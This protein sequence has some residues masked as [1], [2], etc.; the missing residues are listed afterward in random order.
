MLLRDDIS[1]AGLVRATQRLAEKGDRITH[2]GVCPMSEELIRAPIELASEYDFPVLFVASR[3]QVSEDEEGGYVMGLTP[4]SFARKIANV[5]NLLGLNSDSSSNYIRFISVDH[6]GPWYKERE[7]KLDEEEATKS[8]KRT[9]ITCLKASYSGF[10]IDCSFKPPLSVEMNEEKMIKLTVDLIEFTERK[11]IA[12]GKGTVSYEIGTE[13]TAGKSVSLEHFSSSIKSILSEIK[14]R[15]LPEP[16]F[17]VGRTGAEI[18]M[19]E[20][21]GGFDYTAASYLPE[22]ARHFH[23]GFKEHNADY[24]SNPIL[25]LHPHYGITAANVGPSFAAEQTR[26]LLS[27]AEIEPRKID[28]DS[29]NLYEIMSQAVLEKAPFHKWLRKEDEWTADE[30][31]AMPAELRA[32]TVVCGHYVYYDEKV[33]EAINRLYSNLK[34]DGILENPE[35]Y[36]MES[37]K[38][39]VTRYVDAFNLRGSTSKII[40]V[41][42]SGF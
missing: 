21:V 18:R 41:T 11:R 20:N 33:R 35:A 19:L 13:E 7:K 5:E 24:L 34:R 38:K 36:V 8:V 23:L 9:L 16:A 14:K 42:K 12:L 1:L 15:G 27:L 30:L 3:N 10:H 32:V 25:S 28:K 4:E 6:C 39:A 22:V 26:A 31:P 37:V 2:I 40:K 29:S 17:V